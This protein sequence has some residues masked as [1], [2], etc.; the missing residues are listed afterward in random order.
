MA[1]A[2]RRHNMELGEKIAAEKKDPYADHEQI[3]QWKGFM[4]KTPFERQSQYAADVSQPSDLLYLIMY[5]D[6]WKD[7]IEQ[8]GKNIQME[9]M[10][11][12][13]KKPQQQFLELVGGKWKPA[14]RS[15]S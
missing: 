14:S 13:A 6:D 15:L 7:I 11:R 10:I 8:I 2:W 12:E 3:R 5:G 9:R 1:R 4:L